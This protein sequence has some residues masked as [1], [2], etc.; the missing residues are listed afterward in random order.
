FNVG[1]FTLAAFVAA[2]AYAALAPIPP[3]DTIRSLAAVVV[4]SLLYF[5]VGSAL[6]ATVISLTTNERFI[7]VWRQNYSWMPV[8]YLATAL[9]GAALALAYQALGAIGAL[10]FVL[11]LVAAWYSFRLFMLRAADVHGRV[12]DLTE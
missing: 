10:V 8:N 9:N 7:R 5:V 3:D 12:A 1:N 2:H 6:T 11:P 4:S